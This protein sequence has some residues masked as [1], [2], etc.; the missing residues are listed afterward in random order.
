MNKMSLEHS[1]ASSLTDS[2]AVSELKAQLSAVT[3]LRVPW[4]W[5]EKIS[6]PWV[7]NKVS[8]TIPFYG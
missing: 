1:Q 2:A 8:M 4:A 7:S 5:T 6:R 3:A